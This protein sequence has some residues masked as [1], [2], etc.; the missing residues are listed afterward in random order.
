MVRIDVNILNAPEDLFG[1]AFHLKAGGAEWSLKKFETG[2]VFVSPG[3]GTAGFEP[4]ILA[5]ER[6][7][8]NGEREI[9][10]GV[11]LKR[12]DEV[13]ARDGTLVSF[14]LRT[15]GEGSLE[16]DFTDARLSVLDESRRDIENA[17]FESKTVN[18][19]DLGFAV[20]EIRASVLQTGREAFY[21]PEIGQVYVVMVVCMLVILVSTVSYFFYMRW[22]RVKERG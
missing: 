1:A 3:A 16:F 10:F 19:A 11:S 7:G 22:K 20:P 6:I 2:N 12:T 21:Y 15:E 17:V 4:L 8:K 18:T 5:E 9:V 14:Y 13:K